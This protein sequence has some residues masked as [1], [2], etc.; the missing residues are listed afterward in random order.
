MGGFGGGGDE[1]NVLADNEDEGKRPYKHGFMATVR[2]P[3][4]LL[5]HLP[6]AVKMTANTRARGRTGV[7]N[8]AVKANDDEGVG[9]K[10]D[11]QEG[12]EAE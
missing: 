11:C 1:G 3:P 4:L 12:A 9:H 6:I 10:D 7:E 2:Y 5:L 8:L